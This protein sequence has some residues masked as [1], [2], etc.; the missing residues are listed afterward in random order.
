MPLSLTNAHLILLA[1]LF[2]LNPQNVNQPS[3][4]SP[5]PIPMQESWQHLVGDQPYLRLKA[6][7]AYGRKEE[8]LWLRVTVDTTG[9]VTGAYAPAEQP[10]GASFATDTLREAERLIRTSHYRPFKRGGRAVPATFEDCIVVLP[11]EKKPSAH[12]AFPKVKD[13]NSIHITLLRGSCIGECPSY[14]VEIR[15]NGT[16]LY[17]GDGPYVAFTGRHRGV[18]SKDAVRELVKRFRDTDYFSLD[19]KYSIDPRDHTSVDITSIEIAGV[20]KQVTDDQGLQAGMPMEV[21]D[22]E[23]EID[24]VSRSERW[25]TGNAETVPALKAEHFDFKSAEAATALVRVSRNGSSEAV[26]DLIAAGVQPVIKGSKESAMLAAARRGNVEMLSALLDAGAGRDVPMVNQSLLAVAQSGNVEALKLLLRSGADI[27]ALDSEGNTV[28]MLAAASGVPAI[29]KEAL[30]HGL[31][32]NAVQN[33]AGAKE[34]QA[35]FARTALMVAVSQ[36]ACGDPDPEGVDRAEVVRLLLAAGADVNARDLFRDT[37]LMLCTPRIDIAGILIKA[38]ADINAANLAGATA[39]SNSKD[40]DFQ[41]LLAD[42]GARKSDQKA[43]TA[44][45]LKVEG[46]QYKPTSGASTGRGGG[47]GVGMGAGIGPGHGY[48]MGRA[49][50]PQVGV[51]KLPV[52]LTHPR[53][54]YTDE[55]RKNKIQGSVRARVLVAADGTVKQVKLIRH[56]PDGLDEEAIKAINSMVF[57]PAI[58]DDKPVPYWVILDVEFNL[59]NDAKKDKN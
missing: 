5:V 24:R 40:A 45:T 55:A 33:P 49:P 41:N 20:R 29:V 30:S 34:R 14:S 38:G 58:K 22:L 47:F 25:V 8:N 21:V 56:L 17:S 6:G 51:D 48:N 13:W 27:K 3:G 11:P 57:R 32:V 4:P 35:T 50:S 18:I 10:Y 31:D 39:L 42:H 46:M 37:A 1:L 52:A 53:P 43:G 26:R 16:V 7:Q 19:D 44:V 23:K 54:A 15:G 59:Y 28:L 2:A 12:V 9:A 36:C